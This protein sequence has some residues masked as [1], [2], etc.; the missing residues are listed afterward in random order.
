MHT[1]PDRFSSSSQGE[2][3]SPL[4][5]QDKMF[6]CQQKTQGLTGSSLRQHPHCGKKDS[7]P[8]SAVTVGYPSS[9]RP[10]QQLC[11]WWAILVLGKKNLLA[12]SAIPTPIPCSARSRAAAT[13]SCCGPGTRRMS[14]ASYNLAVN[15]LEV[16][17]TVGGNSWQ[18][19]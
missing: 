10:M 9:R 4:P 6:I 11:T 19:Q 16:G 2:A 13:I 8:Q 14:T 5:F 12:V 18:K 7:D 3:K 15:K 17:I 1:F